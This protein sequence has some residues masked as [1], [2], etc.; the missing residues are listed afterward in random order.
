MAT[1]YS[2]PDEEA[3]GADPSR[4]WWQCRGLPHC[5]HRVPALNQMA[6]AVP[7]AGVEYMCQC[8]KCSVFFKRRGQCEACMG[9][10]KKGHKGPCASAAGSFLFRKAYPKHWPQCLKMIAHGI[11]LEDARR[12]IKKLYELETFEKKER[13]KCKKQRQ[14][15]EAKKNAQNMADILQLKEQR[16]SELKEDQHEGRKKRKQSALQDDYYL[17]EENFYLVN[18]YGGISASG[19]ASVSGS[20]WSYILSPSKGRCTS[21]SKAS[22]FKASNSTSTCTCKANCSCTSTSAST[23]LKPSFFM[24]VGDTWHTLPAEPAVYTDRNL[25][26][27]ARHL[28]PQCGQRRLRW[29]IFNVRRNLRWLRCTDWPRC[30]LAF[31]SPNNDHTNRG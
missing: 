28:C 26:D 6:Q 20:T 18:A 22:N 24:Q 14:Q 11:A 5:H 10:S 27:T 2:N 13:A 29:E 17:N 19:G 4:P 12:E 15:E 21:P 25:Y 8:L 30:S 7:T 16:A 1:S 23:C 31:H 3:P 9:M